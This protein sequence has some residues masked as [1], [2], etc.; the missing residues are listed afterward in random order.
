[1]SNSFGLLGKNKAFKRALFLAFSQYHFSAIGPT[2]QISRLIG[3]M[4]DGMRIHISDTT[5]HLLD[6]LGGFR[7]DYRGLFDIEVI[8]FD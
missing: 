4:S 2:T 6:K 1:M 7:C 3:K 5:K 8:F